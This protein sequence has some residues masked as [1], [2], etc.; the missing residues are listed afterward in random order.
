MWVW[1]LAVLVACAA[2]A[3]ARESVTLGERARQFLV[4]LIRLDT[5]NPPGNETRAAEYLKH[6][7]DQY[8]IP[9]EILGSDPA[10]LNFVARLRGSGQ[11]RP[12]LLMA[13][14]DVV[15]ADRQ[16]W[17]ADPFGGEIRGGQS[18]G[19]GAQ[20]DKNLLAAELAVLVE[21]K[22]RGVNLRRDVILLSEADEEAGSSGIQWLIQNAW[23]KIDAAAALNEGGM[24]QDLRSGVRLF[25]VQTSEKIPTR[26]VLTARGTAGHA[27]LPRADNPIVR[28]AH[29]IVR[30]ESDQPVRMNATT[31]RYFA[32]VSKLPDYAWLLPWVS[33]L[34]NPAQALEAA[35]QIRAR[36]LE[37]DAQ[38]RTS[39]SPTMLQAGLKINVIP[40][41]AEAQIDVRRLPNETREEIVARFRRLINDPVVEVSPPAGRRCRP[42]NRAPSPARSTARWS[43]SWRP[44]HR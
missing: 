35:D 19:R 44:P 41:I 20:D 30:L 17:T 22:L 28:L 15:P 11:E 3:G 18:Y 2:A 5:T 32:E 14:S 36:D 12:L 7:A 29:A 13:H 23:D 37:L 21:L 9:A 16:Q 27:S 6:V 34:D 31:R 40:N 38:L 1:G 43:A 4:D 8:G 26:V 25:Q 39:V 24:G 10:R 33:R 42:P